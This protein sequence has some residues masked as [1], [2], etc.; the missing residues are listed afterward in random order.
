MAAVVRTERL[1][2]AAEE[3]AA[4]GSAP[5]DAEA[6]F[7]LLQATQVNTHGGGGGKRS[8]SDGRPT[9]RSIHLFALM[10]PHDDP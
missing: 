3:A 4:S 1:L 5:A 7:A 8:Y 2:R 10:R 6:L 9:R